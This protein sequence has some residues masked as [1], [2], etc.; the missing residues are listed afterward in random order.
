MYG[1]YAC[2]HCLSWASGYFFD[3][4]INNIGSAIMELLS[5]FFGSFSPATNAVQFVICWIT[6]FGAI[7]LIWSIIR[8]KGGS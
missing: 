8:E 3:M 6:V 5:T 7:A 1:Y 2:H 4:E